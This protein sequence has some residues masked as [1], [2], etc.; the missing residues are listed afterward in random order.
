MSTLPVITTNGNSSS[1]QA[2]W[3][4]RIRRTGFE[5]EEEDVAFI[6]GSGVQVV[7]VWRRRWMENDV[8][9]VQRRPDIEGKLEALLGGVLDNE[10]HARL[11][12]VHR[13]DD[14]AVGRD[15]RLT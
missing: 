1:N 8:W 10:R 11:L 12:P 7:A 6:G 4:R 14:P 2:L 5:V 15:V 9:N 13:H 3:V